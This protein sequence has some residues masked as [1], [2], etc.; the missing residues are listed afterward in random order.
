[1]AKQDDGTYKKE[2]TDIV[3]P[4]GVTSF[5]YKIVKNGAEWIGDPANNG[6]NFVVSVNAGGTYNFTF[7]INPETN[8]VNCEAVR[9]DAPVEPDTWTIAGA[10]EILGSFWEPTDEANDMTSE[11]NTTWT[12][13]KTGLFLAKGDY[14]YK[15]VKNHSWEVNYGTEPT[16][17][18]PDGNLYVTITEP[19]TYTVVFTFNSDTK[20]LSAVATKTA[21]YEVTSYNVVGSSVELFGEAWN[22]AL[23]PM[24][25]VS[26][27][28]YT[29]TKETVQL[30]AGDI[31]YKVAAN[32]EWIV[33]YP[34]GG[35][36]ILGIPE[37]G[38]YNVV[39]KLDLTGAEPVVTAEAA[40]ATGIM[41]LQAEINNGDAVV[42]DLRGNRVR[43]VQRGIYIV[44]GRKQVVK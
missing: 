6:D 40:T 12:L 1:M 20:A 21:D 27:G 33:S 34:E 38:L 5:E 37:D 31:E 17:G 22:P 30:T 24:T 23:N 15:V 2:Y 14:G 7:T 11:D 36:N 35:N 9:T 43:N 19:G 3:I 13:T 10:Q 28:I 39:I 42:Y 32:G 41:R 29:W 44:N 16:E 4:E 25:K 18:N 26:D 8:A